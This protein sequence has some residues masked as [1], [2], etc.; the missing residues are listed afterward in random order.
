MRDSMEQAFAYAWYVEY[1]SCLRFLSVQQDRQCTRF[2]QMTAVAF[3]D[4]RGFGLGFGVV[5]LALAWM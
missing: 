4:I 1:K 3:S 2:N 5:G